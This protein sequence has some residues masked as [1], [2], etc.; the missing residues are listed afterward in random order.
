MKA[1]AALCGLVMGLCLI[2][3]A[4]AGLITFNE[5]D[6]LDKPPGTEYGRGLAFAGGRMFFGDS[7][8]IYELDPDTGSVLNSFSPGVGYTIGLAGDDASG[9]LYLADCCGNTLYKI[10]PDTESIVGTLTVGTTNMQGL[11]I[12]GDKLYAASNDM[13]R[14]CEFDLE[15]GGTLRSFDISAYLP[16]GFGNVQGIEVFWDTLFV[17]L[18]DA[19]N[20]LELHEFSLADLSHIGV[21]YTGYRAAA[22]AYDGQ[23]FWLDEEGIGSD[24]LIKF[25]PIPEPATALLLIGGLA[26]LLRRPR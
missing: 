23:Y 3:S 25:Q 26:C 2:A 7:S 9:L 22:S 19:G 14:V 5:V 1:K 8:T 21:G 4:Q 13:W 12:Q 16:G 15:T 10:D 24:G 6:R 17:N 20:Y 18:D 11:A